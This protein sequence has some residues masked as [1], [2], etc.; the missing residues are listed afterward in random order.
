MR[1]NTLMLMCLGSTKAEPAKPKED[2]P[3][4]SSTH[5]LSDHRLPFKRLIGPWSILSKVASLELYHQVQGGSKRG[6]WLYTLADPFE[7]DYSSMAIKWRS[8]TKDPKTVQCFGL[9]C[10]G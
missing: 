5:C 7:L 1:K 2:F 10:A 9:Q 3:S 4:H 8:A 6:T